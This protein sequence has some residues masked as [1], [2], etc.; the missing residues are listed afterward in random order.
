MTAKLYSYHSQLIEF[1]DDDAMVLFRKGE[2]A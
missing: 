1:V 2:G